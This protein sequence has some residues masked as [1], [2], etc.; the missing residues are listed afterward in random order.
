MDLTE[1][2]RAEAQEA[3]RLMAAEK[4]EFDAAYTSVLRRAIRTLAIALD[5]MDMSSAV[6][7]DSGLA[8]P[9]R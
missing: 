2:G 3:G 1:K 5:E 7:K 8:S 4:F 6:D 9:G